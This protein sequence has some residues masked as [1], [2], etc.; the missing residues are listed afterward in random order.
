MT[1]PARI[2]FPVL[3]LFAWMAGAPALSQTPATEAPRSGGLNIIIDYGAA[4]E[5]T[6]PENASPD[7]TES[8]RSEGPDQKQRRRL[9]RIDAQGG[10]RADFSRPARPN[11]QM[12]PVIGGRRQAGNP[13]RA[14]DD[15]QRRLPFGLEFMREF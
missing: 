2:G 13:R 15:I 6:A 1:F 11:F 9:E 14:G 4:I 10:E 8:E 12:N 7:A 5:R 3:F